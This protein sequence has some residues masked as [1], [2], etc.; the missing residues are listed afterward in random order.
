MITHRARNAT[1]RAATGALAGLLAAAVALGVAQLVAGFVNPDASPVIAVGGVAVN[2]TPAPVKEFAIAHFG[3]HDKEVLVAGILIVLAVFSA[4]IGILSRRRIAYGYAGLLVF[5]VLGVAAAVTRPTAT[6]AY[7]LPPIA[8]ALIAAAAL[9]LMVR[10][11]GSTVTARAAARAPGRAL[12]GAGDSPAE[13]PD[14]ASAARAAAAPSAASYRDLP[15]AATGRR[16]RA[17]EREPDRRQ[18]LLLAAGTAAVAAAAGYGGQLLLRSFNVSA[19]RAAIRLPK[20]AVTGPA[21]P[22]GAQL[23]V[24][25][26]T[27]FLTSNSSFYRVD[28]DIVLPQ[29]SPDTW[30]L[31]V[32]GMV[33]K[34]LD[35]SF[36]EL[37]HRPL[38]EADI[39]LVCVSN[40]VGGNLNGNARWLGTSL[41]QLLRDAGVHSGADQILS[42]ST[43]GM[44]ISTPLAAVIDNADAMI[45]VGM[46]GV[47]LPV[48][49]GFPA[50]MMVPGLYGYCSGTKWVTDLNVTTFAAEKAYWTQ[51][52]YA[53]QA[54]IKTM[55]RIDVPK[56]LQ[57]IRAGQTA[58]AGV[59]WAPH[60]GIDAVEVRVDGGAWHRATLAAVP[61]IDTWRQW[62]WHWDATAG[63]HQLEVRATDGTGATQ[64][65]RQVS[66]LPNGASGWDNA[67]VTV[68]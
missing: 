34:E 3:S 65:S 47:P 7:A 21:M 66:P 10:A 22:A 67:A 31:R 51:H 17:A 49:H 53:E 48:A 57:Q 63:V 16:A 33:S 43:E 64:T 55:S 11:A 4:V 61:G 32:H 18:F 8:G 54:A 28:T 68:T 1:E 39:T 41:A 46:N 13:Q 24:R 30:R 52:G 62:V 12:S 35:I 60:R 40:Q 26:I 2:L 59:A 14:S 9:T 45:A 5:A 37:L 20:P 6:A 42:T 44:T 36:D 23:P 19:L 50:R 29:V 58:V 25:G 56:P 38:T 27:P 15:S